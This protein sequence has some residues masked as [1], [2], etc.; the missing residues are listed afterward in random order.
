MSDLYDVCLY[1]LHIPRSTGN[2]LKRQYPNRGD[3]AQALAQWYLSHHPAPSWRHVSW[4][5]Y[6]RGEHEVLQS[7]RE[8]VPQ[9]KGR[10]VSSWYVFKALPHNACI[11]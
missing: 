6:D 8:Q 7:L 3:R 11:F 4:A 9:L 10:S 1:G 2:T 5:L